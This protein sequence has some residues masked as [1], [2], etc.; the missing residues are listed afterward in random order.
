MSMAFDATK[1][2]DAGPIGIFG[3][4]SDGQLLNCLGGENVSIIRLCNWIFLNR[5]SKLLLYFL[6]LQNTISH[7]D[8][9]SNKKNVTV[10]WTAPADFA[11]TV[12]FK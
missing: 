6:L 5:P 8:N 4:P 3:M 2:D 12:V 9:N 10:I 11:G 7:K 1:S